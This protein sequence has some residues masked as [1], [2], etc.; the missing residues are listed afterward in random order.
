MRIPAACTGLFTIRPSAGR[1]PNFQTRS[2]LAG[3]EA[4]NSVNGPLASTLSEVI[5]WAKTVVGQQPWIRDP[6]CLPIPW[7]NVTLK[8]TL[9]IAVLWDDG[10]V[11][12]TPPVARALKETVDKLQKAGHEIIDWE[13][14][15]HQNLLSI[16]SRMFIADGGKSVANLL[17]PTGEPFRPEMKAYSE[18][19]ELGVHAMW[20]LQLERNGVCK[21][22]LDQWNDTGIDAILCTYTSHLLI[23]GSN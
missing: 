19:A 12:P 23:V 9:K 14:T 5:L 7:R 22:Y 8:R 17:E 21:S 16:L 13:P 18:A 3:Q 1:F 6:K 4:V 10:I 11:S 2:G 20:Q 15:W